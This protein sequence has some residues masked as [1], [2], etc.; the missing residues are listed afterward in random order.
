MSCGHCGT[1]L[2]I[3]AQ[4]DRNPIFV[5]LSDGAIRNAYTVKLRNMQARPRAVEVRVT[6]LPGAKIWTD[7]GSREKAS[8]AVRATVAADSVT[9]LRLFLTL[10]SAG[11]ARQDFRFTVRALDREGGGDSEDARFERP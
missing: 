4:Q 8:D 1:R 5:R 9:K 3:S 11:P 10:P 7:A 6:G 2:E